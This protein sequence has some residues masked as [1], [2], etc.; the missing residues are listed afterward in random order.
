MLPRRVLTGYS[1]FCGQDGPHFICNLEGLVLEVEDKGDMYGTLSHFP[2]PG[3]AWL[4]EPGYSGLV[5][6]SG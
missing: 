6:V 3:G 5:R 2:T 4:T 1:H